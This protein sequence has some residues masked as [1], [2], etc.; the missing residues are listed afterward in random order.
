VRSF[1]QLFGAHFLHVSQPK[2]LVGAF[3][4]HLQDCSVL[5]ADEAFFAGDKEHGSVL[6]A[7]ITE[8]TLMIE[9]KGVDAYS[10]RNCI[11]LIMASNSSWVVPAGR[12]ARRYFVLDV[13]AT[14]MQ[15]SA[16]F[17]EVARQM[18]NGGAGALLHFLL[19]TDV[20]KFDVRIVPKTDALA[21]QKAITRRGG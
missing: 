16:Y 9:P 13:A 3:N 7:I 2:H 10:A 12:D 11:H 6:K 21:E 5:F 19:S 14:H 15:D 8:P 20:S 17:G 1:G 18:E 4:R